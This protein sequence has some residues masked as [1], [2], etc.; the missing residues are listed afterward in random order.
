MRSK[1]NV[2]HV[3]KVYQA[4]KPRLFRRIPAQPITEV[5]IPTH[6]AIVERT[7]SGLFATRMIS[8]CF[9]T[10]NHVRRQTTRATM[11]YIICYISF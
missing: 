1:A 8:A 6:A 7:S 10:S 5:R 2:I 9:Q 3:K 11:E 4:R